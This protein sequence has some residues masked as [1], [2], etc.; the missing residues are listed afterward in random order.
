[1]II[2]NK[3]IVKTF[4]FPAGEIGLKTHWKNTHVNVRAFLRGSDN[5]MELLLLCNA[6]KNNDCS[7]SL[8]IP[9]V[10]YA[11]QDRICNDGESF[12]I[13]VFA[14]LINS[15]NAIK[16][17]GWDVHSDV[18]N[19]LIDNFYSIPVHDILKK[20]LEMI[21]IL[22]NAKTLICS[23]DAG[24]LKKIQKVQENFLIDNDRSFMATKIRDVS[25]GN[26]IDTQVFADN[27]KGKT[28]LIIDDICDGGRTF[29]E[30][31]K[32][33]KNIS[34]GRIILY[35]TH[36][37]FSKGIEIFDNLIDEIWTT[38]SYCN[39]NHPKLNIIGV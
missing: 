5:I 30:L 25:N 18:T 34:S 2:A 4:Q 3:E 38:N 12:S 11:R 14:N 15:I 19:A 17:C 7:I 8:E 29:I 13:K 39:I 36:G 24:S 16:V 33:I 31:A 10:P 37:I 21:N 20:S 1:M 6:L 26:I 9:Y 32:K 22:K 28:V 35:V 23:P 27:L